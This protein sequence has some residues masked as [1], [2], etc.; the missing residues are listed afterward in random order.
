MAHPT[1]GDLVELRAVVRDFVNERDWGQLNSPK[2][3]AISISVESAELLELFQWT[4]DDLVPQAERL[5]QV[6]LEMADIFI[7]LIRLADKLGIDL[8]AAVLEK[9][10][11]NRSRF[12]VKK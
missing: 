5:Q 11:I 6:R 2:N 8:R 12:P 3:L 9:M 7:Y 10:I 4:V 1:S